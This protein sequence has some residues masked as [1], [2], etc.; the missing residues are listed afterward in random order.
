MVQG[1]LKSLLQHHSSKTS[2]P[3]WSFIFKVQLISIHDY[4][5]N[6]CF[7]NMYLCRQ[8]ASLLFNTLSRFVIVFLPKDKHLL[9]SWLQSLSSVILEPKKI[10]LVTASISFPI[11]T[12]LTRTLWLQV[13]EAKLGISLASEI[14][15]ARW[16]P[17]LHI[18]LDPGIQ[19]C[20][21]DA[22]VVLSL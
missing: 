20:H 8:R 21:S 18:Q 2:I 16:L 15:K 7:D 9:I 17:Q 6:H 22:D 11:G 13:T 4:W 14:E 5:K 3:L 10:K 19:C 12:G 1:T